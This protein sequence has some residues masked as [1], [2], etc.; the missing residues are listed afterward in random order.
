MSTYVDIFDAVQKGTL[1]DVKHFVE[2]EGIN[3]NTKK[4][5]R[6]VL[7][8]AWLGKNAEIIKT[9]PQLI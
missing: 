4:Y 3:V 6:P 5:D 9:I 1:E 7:D 8:Y 2:K